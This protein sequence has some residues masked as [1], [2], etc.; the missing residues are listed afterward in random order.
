MTDDTHARRIA[1]LESRLAGLAT[2]VKY[3]KTRLL[4]E[5]QKSCSVCANR[6]ERKRAVRR[7]S[8][9]G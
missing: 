4:A 3:F 1:D 9:N 6:N 8:D 5:Q 2:M 7:V